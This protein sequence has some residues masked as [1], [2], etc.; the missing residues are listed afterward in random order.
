MFREALF[1][2]APDWERSQCPSMW[3]TNSE[4]PYSGMLSSIKDSELVHETTGM[5]LQRLLVSEESQS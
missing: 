5:N 1:I 3:E 4:H 2:F